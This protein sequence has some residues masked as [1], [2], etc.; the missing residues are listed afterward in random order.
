MSSVDAWKLVPRAKRI[1]VKVGSSTLTRDGR[2]RPERFT[3]LARDVARLLDDGRQVVVVSSG[4]IAVGAHRL[5][6]PHSGKS[7]PEKQAAAAVGQIGLVELYQRR[8]ARL[9]HEVGQVLLTR[10]LQRL[11]AARGTALSYSQVLFAT[12]W[13]VLV[14]GEVPDLWTGVGA[15]LIAFGSF[16]VATRGETE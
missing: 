9:G 6:W 14:F 12:A 15:A 3:A 11:P 5:G 7:I 16:A 13:G 10:G 1:V 2:L 8:F 4:A